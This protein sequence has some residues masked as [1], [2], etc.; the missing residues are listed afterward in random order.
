M[1][2][3]KKREWYPGAI[4]HITT[5][6]NHRNDIFKEGEDYLLY[7]SILKESIERFKASL[8][9]YCL[10]TNH[11]HLIIETTEI[12]ISEIMKRINS[13][14]TKNYN[15]KYNLVGH[16]FQGRYFSE[17]IET[18]SYTLEASK[19]VHLNPVKAKMVKYPEE[20]E[21]SSYGMYIG[22]TKENLIS[23]EKV[24]SYFKGN[25]RLIYRDIDNRKTFP[26]TAS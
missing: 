26:I 23:S 1:L 18:D 15:I 11:V 21:W 17:L 19:Y 22:I 13:L 5:R 24:L 4:Y 16:L 14:Y 10:M 25:S 20:Y 3:R 2:V 9:C 6:G 8:Y 12:K 7:L